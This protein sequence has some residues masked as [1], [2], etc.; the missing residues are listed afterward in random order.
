[1]P[2]HLRQTTDRQLTLCDDLEAV[3]DSLPSRTDRQFCLHLARQIGRVLK[4][5]HDAEEMF[6]FPLI[7]TLD[8]GDDLIATLRLEHAEDECFGEE[9]QH[10]LLQLGKGLPVMPPEAIGYMLRGF[11][12]GI[13]RHLRR[14]IELFDGA[15]PLN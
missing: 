2:A 5:A 14:E 11:F 7:E 12:G 3:A 13:R 4:E 1:L 6:L 9:V 8:Q 10:E 15:R